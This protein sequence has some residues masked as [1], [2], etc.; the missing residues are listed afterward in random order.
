MLLAACLRRL[1][2]P[3]SRAFCVPGSFPSSW[4]VR[5]RL[6]P[7]HFTGEDT[8]AWMK[9]FDLGT[10]RGIAGPQPGSA[11]PHNSCPLCCTRLRLS[12]DL[13]VT[14]PGGRLQPLCT[15]ALYHHSPECDGSCWLPCFPSLHTRRHGFEFTS[16]R[17][18]Q[19]PA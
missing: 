8:E 18:F 7:S 17:G 3:Q 6:A 16:K 19:G 11:Q 15:S 13:P 12:A 4:Q 9:S 5:R 1:P 14:Q 2:L 10:S